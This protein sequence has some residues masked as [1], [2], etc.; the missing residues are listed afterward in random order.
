[1]TDLGGRTAREF[2]KRDF[3]VGPKK[4][5]KVPLTERQHN[6]PDEEKRYIEAKIRETNP[7]L[8]S[9]N[10]TYLSSSNSRYIIPEKDVE[11]VKRLGAIAA[12]SERR[13]G[14]IQHI[15]DYMEGTGILRPEVQFT[16]PGTAEA[17]AQALRQQVSGIRVFVLYEEGNMRE[18]TYGFTV[19]RNQGQHKIAHFTPTPPIVRYGVSSRMLPN[20]TIAFEYNASPILYPTSGNLVSLIETPPRLVLHVAALPLLAKSLENAVNKLDRSKLNKAVM[21]EL[22]NHYLGRYTKFLDAVC[23]NW[24]RQYNS[25]ARLGLTGEELQ[26]RFLHYE[27]KREDVKRDLRGTNRF[28]AMIQDIGNIAAS[29]LYVNYQ[30][31]L[32]MIAGLGQN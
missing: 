26:A 11:F 31:I 14:S 27:A 4:P 5:L 8:A 2:L 30:D 29:R 7:Q 24:L 15:L 12:G 9:A 10:L 17:F 23:I 21:D 25:D 1:M 18:F 16:V 22:V 6:A 32:F 20:G 19:G 3:E 13:I 28:A